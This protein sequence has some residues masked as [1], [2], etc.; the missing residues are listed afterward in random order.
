MRLLRR[1]A[2]V[3]LL[4]AI[5]LW[6]LPRADA[7]GSV[8]TGGPVVLYK[9]GWNI[10]AGSGAPFSDTSVPLF[11]YRADTNDYQLLAPGTVLTSGLG[12]WGYFD[13]DTEVTV[14]GGGGT[15]P[16]RLPPNQWVLIGRPEFAGPELRGAD[17][18]YAYDPTTMTF[19]QVSS[20]PP[21][22]GAWA[23]SYAGGVLN[24]IY[25]GAP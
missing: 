15:L 6:L 7:A 14:P 13:H 18:V 5:G 1:L 11:S 12:Y 17:V 4:G 19:Y 8:D 22:Q 20:L 10:V 16:I 24:F 25:P 23:L 21:G 9:Q 2:V 3:V